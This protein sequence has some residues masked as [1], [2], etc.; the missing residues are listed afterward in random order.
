[1]PMVKI[2]VS[3]QVVIPKKIHDLLKLAPG[4]FLEVA[5][6]DNKVVFTPKAIIDK[7]LAEGL[8]DI[9][10]GR[11]AGPFETA[12]EATAFLRKRKR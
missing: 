11:V 5:L 4:D 1:M 7:G 10:K 6:E 3:R 9:A 2:G 8:E 12:K